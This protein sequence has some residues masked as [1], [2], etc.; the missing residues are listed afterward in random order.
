MSQPARKLLAT[1][2]GR[3][4]LTHAADPERIAAGLRP[5]AFSR[6]AL[7]AFPPDAIRAFFRGLGVETRAA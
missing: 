4:N 1:G 7:R 6:M 5:P 2:G 3:C